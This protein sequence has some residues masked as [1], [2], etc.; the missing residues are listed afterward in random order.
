[1]KKYATLLLTGFLMLATL[2]AF[3]LGGGGSGEPPED[4]TVRVSMKPLD[5]AEKTYGWVRITP[6][7]FAVGANRLEPDTFYAVYVVSGD[8]K[9]AMTEEPARRTFDDGEFKFETRL[10]EPFGGEWDKVVL[11]RQDAGENVE[12]GMVPV[13]E[14]SLE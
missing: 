13:L 12:E 1:M 7:K 9:Q 5:E 2:S 14:G 10:E 4:D 6:D 3:A 8:T 11:Y